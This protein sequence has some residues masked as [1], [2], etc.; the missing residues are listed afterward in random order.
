M[1]KVI[2]QG[3]AFLF[4]FS[5]LGWLQ[6]SYLNQLS[7]NRTF[8]L[9]T[10]LNNEKSYQD[11]IA[12]GSRLP[13]FGFK[14]I[15][16]N[17]TFLLFLQYFGDDDVRNR[18]GYGLSSAFFQNII[19]DDPFYQDFYIFL[20]NSVSMNA[21]QP[22]KSVELI[23]KGLSSLAP[24]KPEGSY[25]VWRYK[26]VEELLFLG[27]PRAAERSF[28]TAAKWASK[29]SLP[30]S[31]MIASISQQ[32][33]DFLAQN[34]DSKSAQISAWSSVLTTAVDNETRE[35][36]INE[37]Q[38]LGGAVSINENGSVSVKYVQEEQATES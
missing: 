16:A 36:A 35:R 29:S 2:V 32:T 17:L 13:H 37:I 10:E 1:K 38:A 7:S 18:E 4:S 19:T 5:Y 23:E 11:R 3:I 14:N 9:G 30:E 22:E 28:E 33:A 25:Y 8:P 26:A 34:P 27:D 12:L 6:V 31:D 15:R 20:T 21:A 24:G